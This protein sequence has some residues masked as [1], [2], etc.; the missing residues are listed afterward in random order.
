MSYLQ[1]TV[2]YIILFI[3][4]IMLAVP[5]EAKADRND[6]RQERST[7]SNETNECGWTY[8]GNS[9]FRGIHYSRCDTNRDSSHVTH[10][11]TG[12]RYYGYNGRFNRNENQIPRGIYYSLTGAWDDYFRI[13]CRTPF[14]HDEL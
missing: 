9:N 12:I 1:R 13:P 3:V 2:F 4:I 11:D 6:W 7:Y 8:Y 14:C 10:E 5:L